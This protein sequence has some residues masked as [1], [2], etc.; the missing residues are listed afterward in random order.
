MFSSRTGW[1]LSPNRFTSALDQ[2]KKSGEPLLDLTA[3]NPTTCG[4]EYDESKI[5]AA[6]ANPAAMVYEPE[7]K[8][9]LVAREAVTEYYAA[10]SVPVEVSPENILLTTSTSE[11]YSFI[12]RLL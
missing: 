4:L 1:N 6:L 11:A 7:A 8:G 9:L 5:L 12:F 2:K 10:Q 3:S